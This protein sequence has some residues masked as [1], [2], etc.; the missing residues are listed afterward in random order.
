VWST[1]G[2]PDELLRKA[3]GNRREAWQGRAQLGGGHP[4][5]FATLTAAGFGPVHAH[6]QGRRRSSAAVPPAQGCAGLPGHG[7]RAREGERDLAHARGRNGSD[8]ARDD[9][10]LRGL[11]TKRAR[12]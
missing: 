3:C 12:G 9:A 6:L 2:E 1:D 11:R 5:V 4:A 10:D 8:I 7:R